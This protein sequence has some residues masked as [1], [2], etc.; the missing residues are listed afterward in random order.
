VGVLTL[1]LGSLRLALPHSASAN[2]SGQGTLNGDEVTN[3]QG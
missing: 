2:T 3:G 1:I